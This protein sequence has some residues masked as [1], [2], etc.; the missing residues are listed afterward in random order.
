MT[1][2]RGTLS[3][4]RSG[5]KVRPGCAC[6]EDRE[7]RPQHAP[8][9]VASILWLQRSAG[10]TAVGSLLAEGYKRGGPRYPGE[11]ETAPERPPGADPLADG[12]KTVPRLGRPDVQRCADGTHSGCQCEDT[13][14]AQRQPQ[15]PLCQPPSP[16]VDSP[17]CK[18][19]VNPIPAPARYAALDSSLIETVERSRLQAILQPGQGFLTNAFGSGIPKTWVEALDN[20]DD[21][22]VNVLAQNNELAREV[23]GIWRFIRFIKD[24]FWSTSQGFAFEAESG[25]QAFLVGNPKWCNDFAVTEAIFHGGD[26]CFRQ[27][28]KNGVPGL[29][30]CIVD[31]LNASIHVDKH[32]VTTD[33]K[34]P[35]GM[36]VFSPTA[37]LEHKKDL[38]GRAKFGAWHR[39]RQLR[40]QVNEFRK[41][42][43]KERCGEFGVLL[44]RAR[45][46]EVKA[47]LDAIDE[48]TRRTMASKGI[49][50][51]LELDRRLGP[52]RNRFS[53]LIN[54]ESILCRDHLIGPVRPRLVT[55]PARALFEFGSDQLRPD[56]AAELV[57]TLGTQP[58][59]ADLSQPMQVRGHTDS[60]GS[61]AFNQGLSE[62]RASAVQRLLE[63]RYPNLRGHIVARG[64]GESQPVAP[65]EIGVQD[66][67]EGRRQNRRVEIEFSEVV[68]D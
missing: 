66:N 29:H 46:D 37:L 42:I 16:L 60:K 24:T 18:I 15:N 11:H 1:A 8:T 31:G 64:F 9:T 59:H 47:E 21:A 17:F 35:T 44:L 34:L 10:N 3:V 36:C 67:P 55:V 28:S 41:K 6:A 52:I 54:D 68:G 2:R 58:D 32:Q 30:V 4:R 62:R 38:E 49:A 61:D 20:F 48:E 19:P 43:T 22:G 25:L 23:G 50:G 27:M 63:Q 53:Q 45:A 65:N 33:F 5:E 51:E 13:V 56:A 39:Y 26:T 7:P 57:R 12:L 40:D 14:V